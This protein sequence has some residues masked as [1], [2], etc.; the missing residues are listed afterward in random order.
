MLTS[1]KSE[2]VRCASDDT[3]SPPYHVGEIAYRKRGRADQV[4]ARAGM[5]A[6]NQNQR[7]GNRRHAARVA[8]GPWRR[9]ECRVAPD[10]C[11]AKSAIMAADA[12]LINIERAAKSCRLC[13]QAGRPRPKAHQYLSTAAERVSVRLGRQS[14]SRSNET[15]PA[16]SRPREI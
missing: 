7:P 3:S 1:S 10:D 11:M 9:P 16:P 5:S 13:K 14:A 12:E 6:R 4:G 8:R 15:C 2:L